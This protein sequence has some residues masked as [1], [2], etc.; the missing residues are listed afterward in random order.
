LCL[1]EMSTLAT[2]LTGRGGEVE[3]IRR[4]TKGQWGK[5]LRTFRKKATP[6]SS[7]YTSRR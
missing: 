1:R 7:H 2:R 6:R 3:A 4:E 5:K